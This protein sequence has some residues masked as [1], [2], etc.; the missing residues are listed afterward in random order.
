ME[1]MDCFC[2]NAG[3]DLILRFGGRLNGNLVAFVQPGLPGYD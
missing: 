2:V 1:I 3:R